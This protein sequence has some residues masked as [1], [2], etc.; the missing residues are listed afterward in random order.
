MGGK[1]LALLVVALLAVG[2]VSYSAWR[3]VSEREGKICKACSRPVHQHSR[4]AAMVDGRRGAYCCPACALSE[5]Q[6]EARPVEIVEL[7]DY[8]DG[9]PLKPA[10]AFI[11]KSSDV[12]PCLQH[13][14]TVS[15]DGQPM[16]SSFDRCSPSMLAFGRLASAQAFAHQHGGQVMR[17]A[18]LASQF[19][20]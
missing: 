10:D 20:Q 1:R 9:H 5:H 3:Y 2:G 16:H 18:E 8:L 13:G 11:V 14:A 12:N 4:T 7:S 15:P 17:F 19:R 6:Q